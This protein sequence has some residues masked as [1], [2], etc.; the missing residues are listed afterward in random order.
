MRLTALRQVPVR[1]HGTDMTYRSYVFLDTD[2]TGTT[3]S[4][5]FCIA[6]R[7]LQ[8]LVP[9]ENRRRR[10]PKTAACRGAQGCCRVVEVGEEL[11]RNDAESHKPAKRAAWLRRPRC[12]AIAVRAERQWTGYHERFPRSADARDAAVL[13]KNGRRNPMNACISFPAST[14]S[15]QTLGYAVSVEPVSSGSTIRQAPRQPA[16][17]PA[18]PRVLPSD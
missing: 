11:L 2:G 7:I 8:Q 18:R 6:W 13:A 12:A 5:V 14:L 3:E 1:P 10:S 15:F 9:G 16:V 17:R 4:D